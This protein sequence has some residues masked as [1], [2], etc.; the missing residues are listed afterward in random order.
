MAK[1]RPDPSEDD[2]L[3]EEYEEYCKNCKPGKTLSFHDWKKQQGYS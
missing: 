3:W 1:K 2:L